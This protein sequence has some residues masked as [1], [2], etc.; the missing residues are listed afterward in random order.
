MKLRALGLAVLF[1]ASAANAAPDTIEMDVTSRPIANFR[2]GSDQQRF[3]KLE[4]AG[5]LEMTASS[6]HFGAISAI[7]L[8]DDQ[9]RVLG[10][11]PA[12]RWQL[13]FLG[14]LATGAV[15]WLTHPAVFHATLAAATICSNGASTSP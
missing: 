6:R 1:A 12:G 5:G 8:F 9:S 11:A 2:I 15:L 10:V 7:H 13:P 4:F 14:V 3:G